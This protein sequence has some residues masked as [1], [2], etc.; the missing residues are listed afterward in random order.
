MVAQRFVQLDH[1]DSGANNAWSWS[2][3]TLLSDAYMPAIDP[4]TQRNRM[5]ESLDTTVGAFKV[6]RTSYGRRQI[7]LS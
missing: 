6:R 2:R 5:V 4:V 7:G 3:R 1:G